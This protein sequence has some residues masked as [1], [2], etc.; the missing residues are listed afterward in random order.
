MTVPFIGP[1]ARYNILGVNPSWIIHQMA[2]GSSFNGEAPRTAAI[3]ADDLD[4]AISAGKAEFGDTTVGLTE[5]GL[6]TLL[7][8]YKQHVEILAI[9]D[10]SGGS[11]KNIVADDGTTVLR[12]VPAAPFKLSPGEY[13]KI[14]GGATGAKYAVLAKIDGERIL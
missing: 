11:T 4:P 6:F 5:G 9:D 8:N 10:T 7:G 14:T 13:L 12:A 3:V 1:R 2:A